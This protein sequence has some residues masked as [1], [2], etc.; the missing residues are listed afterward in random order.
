LTVEHLIGGRAIQDVSIKSRLIDAGRT[1]FA[2][3]GFAGTSVRDICKAADASAT[4]IHHYFGSKE[5]LYNAIVDEFTSATFEVPLRLIAKS[6]KTQE[7]FL[8]RLEMF[9]SETFRALV[10]QAPVFRI[11]QRERRSIVSTSQYHAGFVSYLTAAQQAGFLNAD[12]KIELVTGVVLDRLGGQIMYASMVQDDQPNVL[13]DE[14]YA[15]EWLTANVE[16]LIHGL[17]GRI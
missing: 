1:L 8:L 16:V 7:E 14:A 10:A 9:M 5:G 12:L 15:E 2:D 13:N 17:A 4:M 11:I 6:P 3:R